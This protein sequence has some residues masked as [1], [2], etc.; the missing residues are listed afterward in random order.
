METLGKFV[1]MIFALS[2]QLFTAPLIIMWSSTVAFGHFHH[3]GY[4]YGEAFMIMAALMVFSV[5]SGIV[6][7]LIKKASN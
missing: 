1:V 6:V 2:F 3:S 7:E 4:T 5:I